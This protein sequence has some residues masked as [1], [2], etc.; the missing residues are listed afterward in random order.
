M[1]TIDVCIPT[2]RP[3]LC[4]RET[5][6]RLLAQRCPIR[7]IYLL[8]TEERLFDPT[9]IAGYEDRV[10]VQHISQ[11][12]FDHGYARDLM[13]KKSDADFLLFM[14]QDAGVVDRYLTE[15]L[16]EAFTQEGVAGAYARQIP[17]R[18][19]NA[20]ERLTRS[21]NYPKVSSIKGKED[22]KRLGIKLYFCS[23]VCALYRRDVYEQLG[24]FEKGAIFNEDMVYAHRMIEAGYQIAYC[25][26]ARVR[27]SHNYGLLQYFRRSFDMAVS[28]AEHPEVFSAVSS[29]SEGGK[30]VW[31]VSRRLLLSLRV[32][33]F[34]SFGFSCVAKYL[35]Y[36][37][38]KRY[39]HLPKSVV[40]WCTDSPWWFVQKEES[41]KER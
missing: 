15:R 7:N 40:L 32:I 29:E 41:E 11:T 39:Q 24:G 16:M 25:A 23:N 30:L 14:T 2:Y 27:H 36:F 28:Q 13:A 20:V 21:F 4:L 37:L 1:S 18:G 10:F 9:L 38:G 8:N 35:G 31:E 3:G 33:S 22:E 12:Q 5:V 26:E 17:Y 19:C 6:G 34:I